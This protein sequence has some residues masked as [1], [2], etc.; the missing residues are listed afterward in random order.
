MFFVLDFLRI[1]KNDFLTIIEVVPDK[2][3][4]ALVVCRIRTVLVPDFIRVTLSSIRE[5]LWLVIQYVELID[6]VS[7]V[8]RHE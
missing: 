1:G 2:N 4:G 6:K 3:I 5:P 8:H 7:G